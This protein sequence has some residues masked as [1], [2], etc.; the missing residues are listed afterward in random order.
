MTGSGHRTEAVRP[1]EPFRAVAVS[2]QLRLELE[3]GPEQH[4]VIVGDDNLVPL[5][6]AVV[7]GDELTLRSTQ[8]YQSDEPV[9]VRVVVP[10]LQRLHLSG[11]TEAELRRLAGP[12][13]AVT[14]SGAAEVALEGHVDRLTLEVS[15]AADLDA[16]RLEAQAVTLRASGAGA[17]KVHARDSLDVRASGAVSVEVSGRPARVTEDVSGAAVVR[18]VGL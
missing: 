11:A 4:V 17:A 6:E 2:G 13:L 3:L 5:I 1:L 12:E 9:I 15:G 14:V 16:T 10:S 18:R 8:S 7:Q